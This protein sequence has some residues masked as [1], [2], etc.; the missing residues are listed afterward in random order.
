MVFPVKTFAAYLT[1][2]TA[3]LTMNGL[4]VPL[5][6][7]LCRESLVAKAANIHLTHSDEQSPSLYGPAM[8]WSKGGRGCTAHESS[9]LYWQC[10]SFSIPRCG[11]WET[12]GNMSSRRTQDIIHSDENKIIKKAW[13]RSSWIDFFTEKPLPFNLC[14]RAHAPKVKGH[15][16]N[17]RFLRFFGPPC[18]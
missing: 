1:G 13:R 14:A 5:Q 7:T 9:T 15:C 3:R 18:F 10:L 17:P 6:T 8:T 2:K 16:C 4:S 12:T 11:N